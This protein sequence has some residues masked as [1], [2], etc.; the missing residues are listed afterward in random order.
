M[1][2]A[3]SDLFFMVDNKNYFNENLNESEQEAALLENATLFAGLV[4]DLGHS[5]SVDD[6]VAD[7]KA[8][9]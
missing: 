5:V 1:N 8:R 7:F 9:V 4:K 3:L 2:T 6:I